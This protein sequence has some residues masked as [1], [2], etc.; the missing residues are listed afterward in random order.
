MVQKTDEMM[1]KSLARSSV[2]PAR[3]VD[4]TYR[5]SRRRIETPMECVCVMVQL[6]TVLHAWDP[7]HVLVLLKA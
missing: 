3:K 7:C 6:T 4:P 5:E 1:A 2:L